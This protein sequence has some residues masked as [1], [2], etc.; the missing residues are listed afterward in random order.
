MGGFLLGYL[1]LPAQ[2]K[3]LNDVMHMTDSL[4]VNG[5]FVNSTYGFSIIP[6]TNKRIKVVLED[7]FEGCTIDDSNLTLKYSIDTTEINECYLSVYI[8]WYDDDYLKVYKSDY[9]NVMLVYS[10]PQTPPYYALYVSWGIMYFI[11]DDKIHHF[12]TKVLA[13]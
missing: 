2:N 4:I 3:L 7:I 9:V 5:E 11:K 6:D 8:G 1:A 10:I 12:I 13:D